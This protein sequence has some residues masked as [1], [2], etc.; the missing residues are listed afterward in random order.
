MKHPAIQ[1]VWEQRKKLR[2]TAGEYWDRWTNLHKES[3]KHIRESEKPF[4]NDDGERGYTPA[5][6]YAEGERLRIEAKKILAINDVCEIEADMI[7][8]K[9][10]VEKYGPKAIINWHTGEVEDSIK[11]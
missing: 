1:E 5:K 6:F 9:A 2:I 4:V 3:E 7:Y 8:C 11:E 10:V